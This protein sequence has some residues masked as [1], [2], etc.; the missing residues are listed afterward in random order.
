MAKK[1]FT[2]IVYDDNGRPLPKVK[3]EWNCKR[4]TIL[5]DGLYRAPASP[6]R[7]TVNVFFGNLHCQI[8][9]QILSAK[10]DD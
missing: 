6:G 5:A 2:A 3:V 7:D 4:G 8:A 9:V 10:K 1:A